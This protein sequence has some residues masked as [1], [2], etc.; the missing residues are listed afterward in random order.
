M[1][2]QY[3]ENK[4]SAPTDDTSELQQ[5]LSSGANWFYWIAVLTLINSAITLFEGNWS[6]ALG[7]GVTQI[8]DAIAL[9]G[10]QEGSG[11]W[12]KAISFGLDLVVAG[13]FALFGIFANKRQIW[14]F[15][16]GMTLYLLDVAIFIFS[17]SYMGIILHG[18]ALFFLFRGFMA[19]RQ[20]NQL[21]NNQ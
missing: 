4:Q 15:I 14:A 5:Q 9:V 7:L 13:I 16:V 2:E 1:F 17:G 8:I 21:G 18:F 6:F 12:V 3:D 10:V 11:N 19:A 20:L